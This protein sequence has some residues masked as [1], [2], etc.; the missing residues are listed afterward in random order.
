MAA[1]AGSFPIDETSIAALHAAYLSGR[2]TA[3]F[4]CRRI[5]TGSR[6]MTGKARLWSDRH[7]QPRRAG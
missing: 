7:Q 2:A 3:V 1:N 6:R 4:V 5:S